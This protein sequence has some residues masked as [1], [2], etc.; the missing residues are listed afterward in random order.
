MAERIDAG[1]AAGTG[2]PA[3][4]ANDQLSRLARTKP[5]TYLQQSWSRFTHNRLAVASLMVVALILAFGFGAPLVS[6]YITHQGYAE[7][8]LLDRF[9]RPGS[10]GHLLGTDNLGRDV[11]TR[12]AFAVK[13]SMEVA[14]LGTAVALTLGV[15]LGA[16]AGYYGGFLDS[17]IMRLV[18]TLLSIPTLY[19]LIFVGA[20]FTLGPNKLA[21]VIASVGWMGL[22]RLVRGEMLSI[23]GREYVQAARVV[24]VPDSRIITRHI[25]PNVAPILIVWATLRL[26]GLILTEAS[27]SFLGLGVHPPIPSLGNMLNGAITY[28]SQSWML[29]FIPGVVIYI[30]VLAINIVG[31]GLRDALDPR[32]G[33]R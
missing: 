16:I 27:L 17:L 15:A 11:F 22:S 28:I 6:H 8:S 29:I 12:L 10:P 7:Q 30:A 19:L 14:I 13:V 24:G 4:V 21:V 26:P 32:L 1:A 33:E 5:R 2:T 3:L 31:N 9:K 25:I 20:M 23:R 18:D